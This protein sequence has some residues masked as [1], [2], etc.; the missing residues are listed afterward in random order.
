M[1]FETIRFDTP[2]EGIL[3]LTPEFFE[4]VE[5]FGKRKESA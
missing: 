4:A 2:Q 5:A 3:C 1:E